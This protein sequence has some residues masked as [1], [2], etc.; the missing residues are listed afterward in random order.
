ME[1]G[2]GL[3]L[4]NESSQSGGREAGFSLVEAIIAV[5]VFIVGIAAVSNLFILSITANST[6]NNASA[7]ATLASEVLDRLREAPIYTASGTHS[8]LVATDRNPALV[9]GAPGAIG[10]LTAGSLMPSS[11]DPCQEPTTA[12]CVTPAAGRT[13]TMWRQVPGIGGVHVK[14]SITDVVV[15]GAPVAIFIRVRAQTGVLVTGERS[16]AE[17]TTFRSL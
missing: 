11:S 12:D 5:L 8:A 17:F 16:Y 4:H 13:F 14:W 1:R 3:Q 10:G 6:A 15:G 2:C 7:T 9:A